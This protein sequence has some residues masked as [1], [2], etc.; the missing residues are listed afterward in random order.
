MT[1]VLHALFAF[2]QTGTTPF[3]NICKLQSSAKPWRI[4]VG[5]FHVAFQTVTYNTTHEA[6]KGPLFIC[7]PLSL[8]L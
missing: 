1:L 5:W 8:F 4:Q 7:F 3:E 6:L 2:A